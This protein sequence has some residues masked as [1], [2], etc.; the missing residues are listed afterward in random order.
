[1]SMLRTVAAVAVLSAL[2]APAAHA[3]AP[4]Q[5]ATLPPDATIAGVGVGN[6]DQA[7][8]TKAVQNALEPVY[9]QRPIAIRVSH[10]DYVVTPPQAG[11]VIFYDDMVRRAFSLATANKPVVVALELG[12]KNKERDAAI[13]SVAKQLYK[14]PRDARV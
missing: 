2:L 5:P 11:L 8:A 10:R 9:V 4:A 7:D 14:A 3:A 1:M 6:L 13:A 12:V